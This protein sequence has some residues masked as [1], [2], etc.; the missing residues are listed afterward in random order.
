MNDKDKLVIRY[1]IFRTTRPYGNELVKLVCLLNLG[2]DGIISRKV[3]F[4]RPETMV[5]TTLTF[6]FGRELELTKN[7]YNDLVPV[8]VKNFQVKL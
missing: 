8:V 2:K 5:F 6:S 1:F 3:W 4:L 7:N